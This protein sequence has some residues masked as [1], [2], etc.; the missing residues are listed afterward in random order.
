VTAPAPASGT[1]GPDA[2]A[3]VREQLAR[4]LAAEPCAMIDGDVLSGGEVVLTGL[5][6]AAALDELHGLAAG[7]PGIG[8]IEWRIATADTRYCSALEVMQSIGPAVTGHRRVGLGLSNGRTALHDGERIR[9]RI[10]APDFAGFITLDYITNDSSA[11]HLYPQLADPK[12]RIAADPTV[13]LKPGDVLS[14]GDPTA[15]HPAWE[16]GEPYGT[17]LIIA[18]ASSQGLFTVPR[19]ANAEVAA[20]YL[21]DL[22]AAVDAAKRAGVR[23]SGNALPVQV[24]P[25]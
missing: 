6:S 23:L 16:V 9:P 2:T 18:I 20:D 22:A 10:V 11:A 21:R 12:H 15:G 13:R 24:L 5:A 8:N 25:K 7:I 1:I 3:R 19:P 4:I 17:D 14:L